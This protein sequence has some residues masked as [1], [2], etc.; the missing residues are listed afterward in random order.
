MILSFFAEILLELTKI[1]THTEK[2]LLNLH[3]RFADAPI[4]LDEIVVLAKADQSQY[5]SQAFNG[6]MEKFSVIANNTYRPYFLQSQG[7][8]E[9][10]FRQCASL[11]GQIAVRKITRPADETNI[12]RTC[13]FAELNVWNKDNGMRKK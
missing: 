11:V 1:F 10:H 6:N 3:D 12:Y 7:L 4:A 2:Y 13:D 5:S 8:V 9:Q